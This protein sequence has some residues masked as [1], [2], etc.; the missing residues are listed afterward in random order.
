MSYIGDFIKNN[1]LCIFFVGLGLLAWFVTIGARIESKKSGRNVS[2]VPGVGGIL[3]IIGFLF[4]PVKW[5]ALIGLLD[6]D[7]WYF[8]VRVVPDII[9][10]ERDER[11]YIPP[12]EFDDGKVIE[13]SQFNKEFEEIIIEREAPYAHSLHSIC[14]YIIIRKEG[15][16]VLLKNEHNIKVIERIECDTLEECEK[17]ASKKVKW[18]SN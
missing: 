4:S 5:L 14:R 9:R 10:A 1:I 15:K 8:F 12:E 11:N 7:M 17:H 13:Y 6:F 18:N 16:Y 3:I 2:G